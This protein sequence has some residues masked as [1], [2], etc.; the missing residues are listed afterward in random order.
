MSIGKL[1]LPPDLN[2]SFRRSLTAT[3]EHHYTIIKL[4][5]DLN[6]FESELARQPEKN[7]PVIEKSVFELIASSRQILDLS[8]KN[9]SDDNAPFC[10]AAIDY[11]VFEE[12]AITDFATYDEFDDDK[13]VIDQVFKVFDLIYVS[14]PNSAA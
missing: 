1:K 11:L 9:G 6:Y 8:R 4:A 12:D 5:V 10:L 3:T 7:N 13:R 2:E 14:E